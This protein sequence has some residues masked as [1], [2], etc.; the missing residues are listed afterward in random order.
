MLLITDIGADV[1]DTVALLTVVGSEKLKLVA[2]VT[3]GGEGHARAKLAKGWL[4][5]LN[6]PCEVSASYGPGTGHCYIPA[7]LDVPTL[8]KKCDN[9]AATK[10]ILS[11][12]RA[13]GKDLVIICIGAL[14][15]LAAAISADRS[16]SLLGI[17]GLYLQGN[18]IYSAAG[19]EPL[20]A[21]FNFREDMMAA[22][23][24]FE[25]LQDYVP[26]TCLGKYA[27][28]KVGITTTDFRTF[29]RP[30]MPSVMEMVRQQMAMYIK[31][32]ASKFFSLYK[33]APEFQNTDQWFDHLPNGVCCH[34]YDPLL[35]LTLVDVSLFTSEFVPSRRGKHVH[36]L[37]GNSEKCSGVTRPALIA[38]TV[39]RLAN[40]GCDRCSPRPETKRRVRFK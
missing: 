8:N 31:S 37:V 28:Y 22:K 14:S 4:K 21:A 15:P 2:V 13:Y 19:L 30:S 5:C 10:A 11:A 24:V 6:I 20:P 33:V 23:L 1:D 16:G 3:T 27:A 36:T 35:V 25:T 7:D 18:V 9:K 32:D 29:E 38:R 12:V 26:F 39:V 40:Q 17:A 34:P